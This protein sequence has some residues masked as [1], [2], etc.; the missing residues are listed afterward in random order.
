M[1]KVLFNA[2]QRKSRKSDLPIKELL[3]K[4]NPNVRPS[5]NTKATPPSSSL[6]PRHHPTLDTSTFASEIGSK[7]FEL[8]SSTRALFLQEHPLEFRE[9]FTAITR[10][11]SGSNVFDYYLE[12]IEEYP[13]LHAKDQLTL[14]TI[15]SCGSRERC[16]AW[17][18]L[19]LALRHLLFL[20]REEEAQSRPWGPIIDRSSTKMANDLAPSYSNQVNEE[21]IL[22]STSHLIAWLTE[23]L[24]LGTKGFRG[25]SSPSGQKCLLG[26][27]TSLQEEVA[28][29]LYATHF[30]PHLFHSLLTLLDVMEQLIEHV[31]KSSSTSESPARTFLLAMKKTSCP[32]LRFPSGKRLESLLE[33]NMLPSPLFLEQEFL[34][35]PL[36]NFLN[37]SHTFRLLSAHIQ[38]AKDRLILANLR[39]VISIA[40]GFHRVHLP[41]PELIQE[42]NLALMKAVE[43]FDFRRG[44]KFGSYATLWIWKAIGRLVVREQ[45]QLIHAPGQ[46]ILDSQK[47][48]H[49]RKELTQ[50]LNREPLPDELSEYSGISLERMAMWWDLPRTGFPLEEFLSDSSDGLQSQE[51]EP[52]SRRS[53][54]DLK[55]YHV[56]RKKIIAGL[57]QKLPQLEA[58][59]LRKRFGLDGQE[60]TTLVE[61]AHQF[62]LSKSH[63]RR[64]ETRALHHLATH[65]TFAELKT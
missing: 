30:V 49:S 64:I 5:A 10:P 43:K 42:G 26:K 36:A 3:R 60:E 2:R 38:E 58:E 21:T 12:E 65:K 22:P 45:S 33:Q 57:I 20:L 19:P 46:L 63:V 41:L 40:K 8:L 11:N 55:I 32:L 56:E 25:W 29:Q 17:S 18:H 34:H 6:T 59:I 28:K 16:Q 4:K 7:T 23:L 62:R 51:L 44:V 14:A 35:M 47:L 48:K 61:I 15:I 1:N 13:I 53:S 27:L 54:P 9:T 31:Q 39:L 24:H 37:I 52:V 50:L